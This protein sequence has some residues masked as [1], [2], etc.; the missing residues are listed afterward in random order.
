MQETVLALTAACY[1][2]KIKT[3]GV[4]ERNAAL[5]PKVATKIGSDIVM[6]CSGNGSTSSYQDEDLSQ[7]CN[8][9]ETQATESSC[10]YQRIF[11]EA[12]GSTSGLERFDENDQ[13]LPGHSKSS[14]PTI[15]TKV[16]HSDN[17]AMSSCRRCAIGEPV[18]VKTEVSDE[19]GTDELDHIPLKER[20]RML[21][22]RCYS[23]VC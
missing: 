17:D 2:G 18:K 1:V 5:V 9:Q 22:S 14:I 10:A 4:R 13:S 7:N 6:R 20:Q 3:D 12:N 8:I 21:L 11:P 15:E 23:S 19:V 16:E